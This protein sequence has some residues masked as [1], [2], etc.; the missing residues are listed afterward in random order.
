MQK[1]KDFCKR[2]RL[3]WLTLLVALAAAAVAAWAGFDLGQRVDN[4]PVYEIVNDDYTRTVVIPATADAATQDDGTTGLY[5][6]VP[7]KS[8]QR[9]YGVRLDLTTH[10]W[11]FRHGTLYAALLDAD[12]NAVANGELD[13]ITIKD[14]TFAAITFDAPYTAPGTADAEE[15][16]DLAN[17]NM[18]LRL[19][20][21]PGDDWDVYHMLGL[22]TDADTSQ[23]MTRRN[24][25]GT[26]DS[27][28]GH[29]ALQYVVNDSG[30]WS[31][32]ISR[33][34]GVLTF[35]A[36]VA[37]FI[38]LTHRAKLWQV[39]LVCG[40]VLGVAFAFLTPPL[41]G[42]DEY[43][44]L[45]KCYRQSSTLLGQP[46]ADDDDMLLVRSCDAPY[47]KNHTGD[48]GIYAYKEMLE[49]LGDAGCSGETTVSS[50]T[51]VTAD[52]INNTLYLGQIAGITLARM[53]GLGF[54]GMLL[55]GRLCNLALYLALAAAAVNIA[56]QRL[57]GIFA[58][59]ALLAQP[60]SL[61]HISEPTRP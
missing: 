38:L 11:A 4:Q 15:D 33:L 26:T 16:Y 35:A 24:A 54:H 58:G 49:H 22:W 32:V 41:V 17:P 20:Y 52:P 45:A 23:Q 5:L 43:T 31:H 42:P 56:P 30:S 18:T 8:G 51:Y 12:G 40:A 13:C 61:I 57:R 48:I 55:L 9:I 50:D 25:N 14:N 60:L 21:T 27:I 37:G 39:V 53:M 7:I 10:N 3:L 46:V 2:H 6:P 1:I 19:W 47:F 44:H 34:L 29:P 59:A 36:V 28:V